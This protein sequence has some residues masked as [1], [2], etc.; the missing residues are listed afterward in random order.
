MAD[1]SLP[2]P[3]L[4]LTPLRR[5]KRGAEGAA[6]PPSA[7]P[8]GQ[9]PEECLDIRVRRH[10]PVAIEVRARSAR[11]GRA[12]PRDARKERL[13]V[14]VRSHVPVAVEVG[15]SAVR[16]HFPFHAS[17]AAAQ[18]AIAGDAGFFLRRRNSAM[19]HKC[20]VER[21]LARALSLRNF[22]LLFLSTVHLQ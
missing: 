10:V 12:V 19:R 5:E 1:R 14:K 18:R 20:A 8:A 13:N 6:S 2:T 16:R 11:R 22:A 9:H 21:D 7:V 17:V 4:V 3:K 15:A